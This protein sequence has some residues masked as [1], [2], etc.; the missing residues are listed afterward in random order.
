MSTDT[1]NANGLPGELPRKINVT[2]IGA[3]SFF[4]NSILK[5]VV[6]IP[7]SPGGE[8][9]LVD[10]DAERLALTHRLMD[11]IVAEAGA[12]GRWIVRSSTDR[13]E[14]LAGSDYLIN[15]IEVS[16]LA[17]VR[18]DND[19]PLEYG[20][21][22]NIG[23]TIGPGGLFKGLRTIPVWLDIL[24]DCEAQ[25]PKAVVLNYTNPMNMMCLAASR[26]SS[27]QV[28]GLCH[29]V[30]GTSRMLA[31]V[32]DVPYEE[33]RWKCAGIN[34][35]AWFTEFD[36]PS[37]SLYPLLF[38]KA[39]DRQSEFAMAEPVRTDVMLHFGAFVTESSGHLSEY[40]PY[41]RKRPD[42]LEKYT[43]T[44]YRGEEG[45]YAA[46]WPTWRKDQDERRQ[47]QIAGEEPIPVER[48]LEYGAWIIEAIEKN[49]PIVIHGNVSNEGGLIENLPHDGC[50]EVACLVDR[51]GITPTRFGRL[52]KPM[53][54]HCDANMRMFDLAADACIERSKRLAA[55]A[56]MLD[57]LTSAVCC[58]AEIEEMTQRMFEAEAEFLAG[59]R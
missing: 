9:R 48:S 1:L 51:N 43:D 20:V 40:L 39:R 47:R 44:G 38:E 37:G 10:I 35:L 23:D 30:Q 29:S 50:V 13:L 15:C 49:V 24:R 42:L 57:P 32:A 56:L 34:H 27:M 59:Y 41:Y 26:T 53:A 58:P 19:L 52:P 54:A 5:D 16:G 22:Q 45:F 3:G 12:D 18:I 33:V 14:L 21:S 17:C 36:S 7:G 11:K 4:T 31:R 55:Q 28:V 8:L 46:N 25:C 2:M 6:L